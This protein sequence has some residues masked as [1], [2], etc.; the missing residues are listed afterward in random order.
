MA[1]QGSGYD[2]LSLVP[3]IWNAI[4][5][6]NANIP[7]A[8]VY[9]LEELLARSVAL[10]PSGM[11]STATTLNGDSRASA[12]GSD[13]RV[14]SRGPV[15]VRIVRPVSQLRGDHARRAVGCGSS[16]ISSE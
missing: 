10:V 16:Y 6:I 13:S 8:Y 12:T 11:V 2:T 15:V 1:G 4:R 14:A 7:L 5:A 3:A 9:T